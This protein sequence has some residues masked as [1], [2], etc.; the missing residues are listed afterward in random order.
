M[1]LGQLLF[2]AI[3]LASI[4]VSKQTI[5]QEYSPM[6]SYAC[7]FREGKDLNDL[8]NVAEKWEKWATK[9]YPA[10][11]SAYVMT[12]V[13]ATYE[14]VPEVVWLEFSD[15]LS[16]LGANIDEWVQYD[17]GLV[18][19]FDDVIKCDAHM[20]GG[21]F[22]L[23]ARENTQDPGFVQ[24][25]ACSSKDGV[26][27]AQIAKADLEAAAWLDEHEIPGSNYRWDVGTGSSNQSKVDFYSIWITDSL[28]QRGEAIEKMM[29]I[30]GAQADLE[31]IYGMDSLAE[32]D[33]AR[34]Y[35]GIQVGTSD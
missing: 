31:A 33:M 17:G 25:S 26:S 21:S 22:T 19:E 9:A 30:E 5:A 11:Y 34:I 7:E 35:R 8:M 12:P 3:I 1:A 15:S 18:G 24:L 14:E 23:R 32:C 2:S 16:G 20:L 29:N 4:L 27:D 28:K 10:P 13:V 6:E